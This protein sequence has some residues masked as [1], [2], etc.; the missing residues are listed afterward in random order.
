MHMLL[1]YLAEKGKLTKVV[2]QN[3][4]DLEIDVGLQRVLGSNLI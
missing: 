4:D 2:T 1:Q 3:I